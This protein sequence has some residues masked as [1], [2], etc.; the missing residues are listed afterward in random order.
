MNIVHGPLTMVNHRTVRN[1]EEGVAKKMKRNRVS[2]L[3]HAKNDKEAVTSWRTDLTRIL[4]IFNVCSVV[5]RWLLLTVHSQAEVAINTNTN[6]SVIHRDAVNTHT[7]VSNIH[8]NV[9][10]TQTAISSIQHSVTN[11]HT[12]VSNIHHNMLQNRGETNLVCV[13]FVSP[14]LGTHHPLDS[15]QVS[16]LEHYPTHSDMCF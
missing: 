9:V 2:R 13:T 6:T 7:V 3:F 14:A 15:S 5:Y 11:T 12:L 1:I 16:N 4:G 10:S 8:N